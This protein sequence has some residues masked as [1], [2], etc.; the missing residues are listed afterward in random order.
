MHLITPLRPGAIDAL[1][2]QPLPSAGVQ[3]AVL[4]P[5]DHYAQRVG[6]ISIVEVPEQ[7]TKKLT[8]ELTEEPAKN[9][10]PAENSAAP[11]K[12]EQPKRQAK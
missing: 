7:A 11:Q 1:T 3:R 12:T 8:E 2:G 5:P 9:T 4:L 6:D 10:P